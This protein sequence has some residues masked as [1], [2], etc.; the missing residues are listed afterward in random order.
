M[1]VVLVEINE[2]YEV[3][4]FFFIYIYIYIYIHIYTGCFKK[5][6]YNFESL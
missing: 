1:K 5:R 4:G 3:M 6:I 2:P